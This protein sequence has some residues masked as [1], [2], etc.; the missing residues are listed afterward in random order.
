MKYYLLPDR[1][2]K[3]FKRRLENKIYED[4]LPKFAEFIPL[5]SWVHSSI[6]EYLSVKKLRGMN[7]KYLY[8]ILHKIIL[9][10]AEDRI[11]CSIREAVSNNQPSV[12]RER[13]MTYLRNKV[14]K[15]YSYRNIVSTGSITKVSEFVTENES[16]NIR[17]LNKYTYTKNID[18]VMYHVK[19]Y[20]D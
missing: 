13:R 1:N 3:N 2:K 4:L 16:D 20:V 9:G 14:N 18:I 11:H 19:K 10:I 5:K 15:C 6:E 12:V 8:Q 7:A 17:K